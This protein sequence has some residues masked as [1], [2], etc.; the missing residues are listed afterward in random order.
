MRENYQNFVLETTYEDSDKLISAAIALT[1]LTWPPESDK[2]TRDEVLIKSY[3][4]NG[5]YSHL[6]R[7]MR[8]DSPGLPFF[9]AY[10]Q[11]LMK[12]LCFPSDS[13]LE[14]KPFEGKVYR[15]LQI[16]EDELDDFLQSYVVGCN[17]TF[18]SFLSTS[19]DEDIS[20]AFGNILFTIN[21]PTR[22]SLPCHPVD[23]SKHS[24]YPT[25]SEI[26]FPPY[27]LYKI[28]NIERSSNNIRIVLTLTGQVEVLPKKRVLPKRPPL[29]TVGQRRRGSS[30]Y[31][32]QGA[33]GACGR[34]GRPLL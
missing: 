7:A 14:L 2:Q 4:R 6:N 21:V 9:A 13:V 28:E 29:R 22:E 33:C 17:V 30:I 24:A 34:R 27:L 3:T 15:G 32:L 20:H 1:F 12:L 18:G 23:V 31:F 25:E 11:E 5:L 8:E 10:I 26:L 16:H 19:T